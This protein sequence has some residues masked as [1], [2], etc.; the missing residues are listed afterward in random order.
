MEAALSPSPGLNL[1]G[2]PLRD[3]RITRDDLF[4]LDGMRQRPCDYP[5][6]W[7]KLRAGDPG[8]MEITGGQSFIL[9]AQQQ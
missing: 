8:D 6:R 7:R 1:V 5:H 4:A 9:T 3:S 2:L